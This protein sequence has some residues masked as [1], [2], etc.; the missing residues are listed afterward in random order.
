ML[1]DPLT[2]RSLK[3]RNRVGVSP[4]C[5]YCAVDGTPND[6]HLVHLGARAMGG[7]KVESSGRSESSYQWPDALQCVTLTMRKVNPAAR[8]LMRHFAV[9]E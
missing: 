9:R 1:F 2:L 3:L 6:W 7:A 5:Q 4:M 8:L